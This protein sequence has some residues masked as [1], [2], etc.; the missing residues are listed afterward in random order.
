MVKGHLPPNISQN[1]HGKYFFPFRGSTFWRHILEN[2]KFSAIQFYFILQLVHFRRFKILGKPFFG[3]KFTVILF[4]KK[5]LGGSYKIRGVVVIFSKK[6]L[7]WSFTKNTITPQHCSQLMPSTWG[8]R[9]AITAKTL[10]HLENLG[11]SVDRLTAIQAPEITFETIY[12][13]GFYYIIL[14]RKE[15]I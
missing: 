14:S 2:L 11:R 3:S 8:V 4:F 15:F 6:S 1:F 7:F 10:L 5:I 12:I 13:R 9:G